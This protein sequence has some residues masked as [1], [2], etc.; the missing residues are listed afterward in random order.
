MPPGVQVI[1]GIKNGL[2][3]LPYVGGKSNFGGP[4]AWIASILDGV[5]VDTYVEPCCGT[6]G[7]LLRRDPVCV[8]VCNDKDDRVI[9]FFR[10]VRDYPM[11]FSRKILLTPYRSESEFLWAKHNLHHED[12]IMAAIAC[13]IVLSQSIPAS[14]IERSDYLIKGKMRKWELPGD[15]LHLADRL[16]GVRFVVS[17]AAKIIKQFIVNSKPRSYLRR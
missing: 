17:D 4:G 5:N 1:N 6:L 3:T 2:R 7:I 13:F 15:V 10:V 11:E 14:L 9:N 12:N 8:E 16:N